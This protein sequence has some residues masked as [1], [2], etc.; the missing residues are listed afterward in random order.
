[1]TRLPRTLAVTA[2]V[3]ALAACG[4]G[5]DREEDPTTTAAPTPAATSEAPTG[6]YLE[7]SDGGAGDDDAPAGDDSLV[8][9][10]ADEDARQGAT[11][12]ALATAE[13]WVQGDTMEQPEWNEALL[14]TIAPI[15][16]AAYD[17]KWWG[18]RVTS[19]EITG[20]PE[21]ADATMTTATATVPTDAG[22]LTLT[23]TR[24]DESADWLTTGITP[25]Q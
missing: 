20:D 6:P 22:D 3:L 13:V 9:A 12:A 19:T 25:P 14:E 11:A 17:S 8:N 16:H 21:L 18:Y 7:P 1:M 23:V 24:A 15:S 5:N 4:G 2:A 10:E